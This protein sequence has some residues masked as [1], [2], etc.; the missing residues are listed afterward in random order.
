[1]ADRSPFATLFADGAEAAAASGEAGASRP[2]R[3]SLRV[4]TWTLGALAQLRTAL[5]VAGWWGMGLAEEVCWR[6]VESV[7]RW[8]LWAGA[9]L[10]AAVATP[11]V[12]LIG[13][14]ITFGITLSSVVILGIWGGASRRKRAA[15]LPEI[16]KSR[17]RQRRFRKVWPS[18]MDRAKCVRPPRTKDGTPAYPQLRK[19][20][21]AGGDHLMV[22]VDTSRSG[23]QPVK[24]WDAKGDLLATLR[25]RTMHVTVLS[26]HRARIDIRWRDPLAQVVRPAQL[27]LPTDRLRPVVGL[28]ENS[29]PVSIACYLPQLIIGAQGAGKSSQL[30]AYLDGLRRAGI[31]VR[32]RVYDPKGGQEFGELEGNVHHYERQISGWATLV[33]SARKALETRQE[34]L[35]RRGIRN[36]TAFTEAEPL[37]I[38]VIDE[39]LTVRRQSSGK[40]GERAAADL[41]HL[42]SQGRAAGYVVV[43]LTQDG[44]KD[45]VGSI[46]ELFPIRSLLRVV[47][48]SMVSVA[49]N[50]PASRAPAHEIP[51]NRPGEA[52]I[53]QD[54]QIVRYRA[55]HLS[56][57]DV[58]RV[59]AWL[60]RTK[61]HAE[62]R[63]AAA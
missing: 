16:T 45:V 36:F 33:G 3:W 29:E 6:A 13:A 24:L 2:A 12:S 14:G 56:K 62:R 57:S 26:P 10:V 21:M 17:H 28:G 53:S 1:M 27:P 43:A 31:P 41:E 18:A 37:D 19:L 9:V 46:A 11:W 51:V 63:R 4:P 52:Y 34:M 35:R 23:T 30:W 32:L 48:D 42:L 61:L 49:L 38:L 55:A 40:I 15:S 50:V 39:L 5:K 25:A 8:P 54:G 60:R 47:T 7:L 20:R 59:V 22:E 44:T 58:A